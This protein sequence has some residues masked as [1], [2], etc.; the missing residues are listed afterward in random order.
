MSLPGV[1]D[2]LTLFN[3][4]GILKLLLSTLLAYTILSSIHAVWFSPLSQYPGRRIYAI[5]KIPITYHRITGS[6]VK[7][8]AYLHEVYGPVVRI[9]PSELSYIDPR[10][11]ND[12]YGFKNASLGRQMPK[13]ALFYDLD[14][15][16]DGTNIDADLDDRS[17]GRQRQIFSHAFSDRALRQQEGLIASYVDRLVEKIKIAAS[18]DRT[19][20]LVKMLNFTTFDIMSDL[21]FG[22]PLDLLEYVY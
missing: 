6:I 15:S 12:I 2:L 21:T 3:S 7:H 11:W 10:A 4:I 22:E 18:Q 5:S 1:D 14:P 8:L 13:D 16:K 20:D 9:G 17:H 19:V